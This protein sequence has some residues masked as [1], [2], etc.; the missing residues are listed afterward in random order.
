M[1]PGSGSDKGRRHGRRPLLAP[2]P[3]V[4]EE[5]GGLGQAGRPAA[6]RRL[7]PRPPRRSRPTW[8]SSTP[9]PSSRP[10]GRSRWTPCSSWP[11]PAAPGPGWW[12]PAAWPSATATELAAALPEVDLVAGF[13]EPLGPPAPGPRPRC[14]SPSGRS[15]AGPAL[16]AD[17]RFDL[18]SLPRPARAGRGP[19]SRWPRA[20]TGVCG[21][22]AIP[23]FRGRSAPGPADDVLAE[24]AALVAGDGAR[25]GA[26]DR[27]GGAGPGLVRPGPSTRPRR[28]AARPAAPGRPSSPSSGRSAGLVARTR[29]LYLY[30]SGLT[31]EL[32]EAV[33]ATGVPYFDLSLQH[34]S[35]PLLARMRRWGDGE[36]FLERIEEIRRADP[37]GDVPVLVHPGL[38]RG[39]RGGPRPAAGVPARRP[40][41][42]GP[43]SSPSPPRRA[44][45]PSSLADQVPG[46]LALERLRECAELQDAITARRRD[47]LVG[48]ARQVLVDAPGVGRTVHEAPEIDGVVAGPRRRSP[49]GPVDVVVTDVAGHRPGGRAGAPGRRARPVAVPAMS[50]AGR[51]HLR[52]VGPGHAGQ[53]ADRGPAAGHPVLRR[54]DRHPGGD[55]DRPRPSGPSWPSAT[56]WTAGSPGGRAR[57]VRVPSWIPWPTR[58]SCWARCSP[59]P[60]RATCLGPGAS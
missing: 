52:A 50:D 48:Q 53:R 57:P 47:A 20:A 21:F 8:S 25:P 56:E 39:D 26:R 27:A 38:P 6:G 2:H 54:P 45:T 40:S 28:S 41:S 24:V 33:L 10:P 23:S 32:V 11:T 14:R 12:S 22:C 1:R 3:R 9:V 55:L 34:V 16:L 37:H 51:P 44:P 29:L 42:T 36:R 19:T 31:D 35:R 46:E 58:S 4:S 5:P 43:A 15:A 49:S 7:W 17:A 59:W 60:P 18:L 13:G 30:P